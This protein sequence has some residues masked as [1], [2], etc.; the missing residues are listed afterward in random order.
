MTNSVS[1][2]NWK[3]IGQDIALVQKSGKHILGFNTSMV[4]S[5]K[6]F[7]LKLHRKKETI[8][9]KAYYLLLLTSIKIPRWILHGRSSQV[10]TKKGT[11]W[12]WKILD[13]AFLIYVDLTHLPGIT[14]STL[15]CTKAY[16]LI[17][18]EIKKIHRAK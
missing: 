12:K 15:Y 8:K 7:V 2:V 10:A 9:L 18:F 17:I 4:N 5:I 13:I 1:S 16:Q 6:Y 11:L 3:T 14:V